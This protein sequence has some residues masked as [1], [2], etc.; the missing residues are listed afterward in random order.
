MKTNQQADPRKPI[1]APRVNAPIKLLKPMCRLAFYSAVITCLAGLGACDKSEPSAPEG[2]FEQGDTVDLRGLPPLGFEWTSQTTSSYEFVEGSAGGS[3]ST[4]HVKCEVIAATED[5]VT[6]KK[7]TQTSDNFWGSS[8]RNPNSDAAKT[9]LEIVTTDRCGH[10]LSHEGASSDEGTESPWPDRPLE[11]GESFTT[12][13]EGS[14]ITAGVTA[15]SI[16]I[17]EEVITVKGRRV[18]VF[19]MQ[20]SGDARGDG[21]LWRDLQTG[22]PIKESSKGSS[23]NAQGFRVEASSSM[24]MTDAKGEDWLE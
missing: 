5:T 2:S 4:D 10:V 21:T 3:R 13:Y 14:G 20:F 1:P 12:T 19:S 11:I 22:L 8:Y 24:K 17:L 16:Y 9:R 6:I 7:T 15:K 23:R 18:A